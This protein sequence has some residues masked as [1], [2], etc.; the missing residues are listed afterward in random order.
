MLINTALKQRRRAASVRPAAVSI[1][2]SSRGTNVKLSLPRHAAGLH[3]GG[4]FQV[5]AEDGVADINDNGLGCL[6]VL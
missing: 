3:K 2:E 1:K 4:V 6:G 5:A